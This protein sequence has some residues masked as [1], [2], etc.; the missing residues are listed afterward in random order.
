MMSLSR[1][2]SE[3][4]FLRDEN[5]KRRLEIFLISEGFDVTAALKRASDEEI[6]ALSKSE[7]RVLVTNDV[8]FTNRFLFSKDKIFSVVWLRIPQ[9]KPEALLESFSILLKDKSKPEDFEGFLIELSEDGRFKSSP[10]KSLKSVR[11]TK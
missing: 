6:A 1:S 3:L 5:V 11:L 2:H 8:H 7:K 4:K 10:I 9:D